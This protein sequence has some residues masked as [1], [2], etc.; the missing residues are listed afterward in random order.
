MVS[1]SESWRANAFRSAASAEV[2]DER[3]AWRKPSFRNVATVLAILAA[4]VVL[5]FVGWIL[6]AATRSL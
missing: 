3:R 6:A 2:A 1:V 5:G 4:P